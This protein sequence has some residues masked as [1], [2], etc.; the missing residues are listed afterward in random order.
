MDEERG[1]INIDDTQS[2]IKF[3][4]APT[5]KI[6]EALTGMLASD[7]SELRLSAGRLV[8][9][10]IKHKFLTQLGEE[11]KKYIEKGKIKENYFATHK[12][13]ASLCELLKFIDEDVPD[14]E[15]FRAM[16]SIFLT[17]ISVE[18]ENED[19]E[20]SYELLKICRKLTSGEL[21]ILKAAYDIANGKTTVT[22]ATKM[23]EFSNAAN[24]LKII[25]EHLGHNLPSLVEIYEKNLS[26][27]KLITDRLY[28]DRSGFGK[29]KYFRLTTLGLKLCEFIIKYP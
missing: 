3:L 13:Q 12:E 28:S 4:K 26:E 23:E 14:E 9:A 8:Q 19:K 11:I 27:L 24:W 22:L 5:I 20:L 25:S 15:R 16:K 10:S 18:T 1:L 21:L 29:S 7:K 2:I 6:A 17:S